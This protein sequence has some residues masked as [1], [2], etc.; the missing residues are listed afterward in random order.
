MD[1]WILLVQIKEK[2]M[3]SLPQE[4]IS[5]LN[6]QTGCYVDITIHDISNNLF[7]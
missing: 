2:G 1:W 6:L 5:A 4:V 7:R 3:I